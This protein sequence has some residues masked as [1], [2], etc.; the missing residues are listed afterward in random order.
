MQG[1]LPSGLW[2]GHYEQVHRDYS[3][4]ATLEFEDGLIRGDG[5][6]GIGVFHMRLSTA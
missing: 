5:V 6:D 1:V 2:T 3:Q 4:Q